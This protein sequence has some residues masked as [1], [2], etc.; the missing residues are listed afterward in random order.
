MSFFHL[1]S[2]LRQE[3]L[4]LKFTSKFQILRY[5]SLT[6]VGG[7]CCMFVSDM[8]ESGCF[9]ELKMK[10]IKYIGD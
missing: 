1:E 4:S 7:N 9:S 3:N 5:K 10:K 8:W 6:N 2:S